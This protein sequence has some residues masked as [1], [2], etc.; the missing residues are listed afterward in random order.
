M[1]TLTTLPSFNVAV[2]SEEL[3]RVLGKSPAAMTLI[4]WLQ[5][6]GSLQRSVGGSQEFFRD[7][8]HAVFD[9]GGLDNGMIFSSHW[10]QEWTFA[11]WNDYGFMR[12]LLND[13]NAKNLLNLWKCKLI[14]S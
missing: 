1:E 12:K 8:A 11:S 10:I 9:S 5:S 6:I 4:H 3:A 14:L 13:L 7:A 2:S